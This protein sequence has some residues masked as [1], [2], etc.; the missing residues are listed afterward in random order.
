[1]GKTYARSVCFILWRNR[2]MKNIGYNIKYVG[3][4]LAICN[5]FCKN[6]PRNTKFYHWFTHID[7]EFI[8]EMCEKCA[9]REAWGYNYKS[10]KHYKQW[11]TKVQDH[12]KGKL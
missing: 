10:N 3:K 9:L 7:G 1:M 6:K 12:I 2:N 5:H 8:K 11:I 4:K